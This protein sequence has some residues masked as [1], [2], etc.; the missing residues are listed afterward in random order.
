MACNLMRYQIDLEDL[1]CF[2]C[3]YNYNN[4]NQEPFRTFLLA[5]LNPNL[6]LV[7]ICS[8]CQTQSLHLEL[9]TQPFIIA[10]Q[11]QHFDLDRQ[12]QRLAK[13]SYSHDGR[14]DWI[15]FCQ[16]HANLSHLEL[17]HYVKGNEP[18]VLINFKNLIR[19]FMQ[20]T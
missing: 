7:A 5:I 10:Q 20:S 11:C 14:H 2:H 6:K 16:C 9:S 17:T 13:I 12:C 1:V 4:H 8:H 18:T 3:Q 15:T 19:Q